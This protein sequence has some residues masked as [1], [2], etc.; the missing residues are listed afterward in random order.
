VRFQDTE[1]QIAIKQCRQE[2]S[3]RNKER[4]CL[5]IQ[6]MRRSVSSTCWRAPE[7]IQ[8]WRG[9]IPAALPAHSS[10]I[11]SFLAFIGKILEGGG[12]DKVLTKFPVAWLHLHQDAFSVFLCY[13]Q[14][15]M[16]DCVPYEH[17]IYYNNKAINSILHRPVR[18][19]L[20]NKAKTV[21]VWGGVFF[22]R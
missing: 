6:I 5:E 3:E 8:R 15:F 19:G 12:V 11:R 17:D 20:G 13:K 10:F 1:E 7:Q 18:S 4:W 14:T 21:C 9:W 22:L 16:W 2:L